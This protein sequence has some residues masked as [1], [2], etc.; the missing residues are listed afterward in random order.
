MPAENYIPK[1]HAP[2]ERKITE[3]FFDGVPEHVFYHVRQRLTSLFDQ[4]GQEI[5]SRLIYL[6][7]MIERVAVY[8]YSPIEASDV[9]SLLLSRWR[10][11]DEKRGDLRNSQ[12]HQDAVF[13]I[14]L[15]NHPEIKGKLMSDALRRMRED[16]SQV[17]QADIRKGAGHPDS[18]EDL[19]AHWKRVEPLE[20]GVKIVIDHSPFKR[21]E[22]L[23]MPDHVE[24]HYHILDGSDSD[25]LFTDADA[26][27]T[28]WCQW[29]GEASVSDKPVQ[30]YIYGCDGKLVKPH[31]KHTNPFFFNLLEKYQ[32][33]LS[34]SANL[35]GECLISTYDATQVLLE[36]VIPEWKG[37]IPPAAH[38]MKFLRWRILDVVRKESRNNT[39]DREVEDHSP[40]QLDSVVLKDTMRRFRLFLN[41]LEEKGT[42]TTERVILRIYRRF[43]DSGCDEK[44][45]SHRE[46][47]SMVKEE[48]GKTVSRQYVQKTEARIIA[49][50]KGYLNK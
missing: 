7:P 30:I 44:R 43:V 10:E 12:A 25:K 39:L 5:W 38:F 15:A 48:T 2:E 19:R 21:V 33:L 45:P 3:A 29:F 46:I 9:R 17:L 8:T 23:N 32:M 41:E 6:F 11:A 4:E 31:R 28:E 20:D 47:A 22:H 37:D 27:L 42:N 24:V 49:R 26:H 40:N 1:K 13:L 34:G 18:L 16:F 14:V 50:L 36:K 35:Y